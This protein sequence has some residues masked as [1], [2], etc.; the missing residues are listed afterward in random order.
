M[1]KVKDNRMLNTMGSYANG[2][3]TSPNQS[4]NSSPATITNGTLV[5]A[6]KALMLTSNTGLY[7][8]FSTESVLNLLHCMYC[9]KPYRDP[10]LLHCGHT[11]C[12]PCLYQ[13]NRN[14]T[15]TFCL[16]LNFYLVLF[17]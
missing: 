1:D 2:S 17:S 16:N 5:P 13:M 8:V 10:R 6:S 14:S 11:Y 7:K 4:S 3:T 12:L 15:R 9:K